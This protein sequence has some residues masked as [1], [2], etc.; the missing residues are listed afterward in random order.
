MKRIKALVK[1]ATTHLLAW[2]SFILACIGGLAATGTFI[3]S[4][5]VTVVQWGPWWLPFPLIG[6]GLM[7]AL[8]DLGGD[9]IPNRRAVYIAMIWP[10]LFLAIPDGKA[11]DKMTTWV[12]DLNKWLDGELAEWVGRGGANAIMTITAATCI[13]MAV[14]WAH[15]Y[16]Q[17]AKT[18]A[19]S[20]AG[21]TS[22][23][24]PISRRAR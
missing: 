21:A 8:A 17:D 20:G 22:S 14:V 11:R 7:V 4:I 13:A 3:G 23:S 6:V 5:I 19:N 16:A 15:R 2:G 18:A 9:G 10:S 12:D 1:T 24:T